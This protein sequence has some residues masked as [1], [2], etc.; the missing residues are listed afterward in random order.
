MLSWPLL[1][2]FKWTIDQRNTLSICSYSQAFWKLFRLS[3]LR[4][5]CCNSS[6]RHWMTFISTI[7]WDSSG[8]RTFRDTWKWNC[9]WAHKGG[10]CSPVCWNLPL[11]SLGRLQEERWNPALTTS[12]WQ[13][14]GVLPLLRDR[15]E[16]WSQ[17]QVL[18]PRLGQ[19]PLTEYNP[20]SLLDV[21]PWEDIC[22]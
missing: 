19:Y 8:P 12:M 15:L 6:K 16:N 1:L 11:G 14:S 18:L 3:K 22:T 21:T 5:H 7:L 4:P 17:A 10:N 9:W 13:C 2:K 20:G